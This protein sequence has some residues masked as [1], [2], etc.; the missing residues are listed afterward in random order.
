VAKPKCRFVLFGIFLLLVLWAAA[1][2]F[3]HAAAQDLRSKARWILS[4]RDGN[5]DFALL[6]SSRT[7]VGVDIPTLE[8][9]LGARGI[10]LSI[11]GTTYPEQYLAL[12]LFLRHNK[13]KHL[14]LDANSIGLDNSAFK[15]PFHAYEYLPEIG[16]DDVFRI[17][18]DNF[19][20]QV[21]AWRYVPFYKNAQFNNRL[22]V[23]QLYSWLKSK[24]DPRVKVPEFDPYGTWL[25]PRSKKDPKFRDDLISKMPFQ[26]WA[27]D[28]FPKKYFFEVLKL[29]REKNIPVTLIT[30]PEY[31][32]GMAKQRNRK[33]IMAFYDGVAATNGISFLR[34]DNDEICWDKSK[35][36]NSNHLYGEGAKEFS[37]RL[38][39]RLLIDFAR[40][41][42]PD[43]R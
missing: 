16:D 33:Q 3:D 18:R 1:K 43:G 35:F 36:F 30:V 23:T 42:T 11:E 5:Y 2:L 26:T 17:L 6:G 10:N 31:H 7:Y 40:N 29:A 25:L 39:Q 34:F 15:Y 38:G 41:K 8:K 28:A 24:R 13:I 37:E 27:I 22:G 4:Q 9:K 21:Y 14:I 32:L 12:Q 19:G 20:N